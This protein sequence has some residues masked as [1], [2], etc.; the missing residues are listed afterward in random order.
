MQ[1]T[2]EG[3]S[4]TFIQNQSGPGHQEQCSGV[5]G[6]AQRH[7]VVKRTTARQMQVWALPSL[8]LGGRMLCSAVFSAGFWKVT[9]CSPIRA[10]SLRPNG[11]VRIYLLKETFLTLTYSVSIKLKLGI[12]YKRDSWVIVTH[13]PDTLRKWSVQMEMFR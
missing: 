6:S 11:F 1:W 8:Q 3:L 2:N 13:I 7:L 5:L 12:K 9:V 4:A 10:L